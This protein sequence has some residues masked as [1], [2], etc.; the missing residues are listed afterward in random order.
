MC[1]CVCE[2]LVN[3]IFAVTGDS[4]HLLRREVLGS[5]YVSVG[6]FLLR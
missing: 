4:G 5:G 1:V 6:A 3:N 2:I